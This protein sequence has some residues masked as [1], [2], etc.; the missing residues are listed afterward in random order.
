MHLSTVDRL[1]RTLGPIN[2]LVETL[3]ERLLPNAVAHA[4]SW[5]AFDCMFDWDAAWRLAILTLFIA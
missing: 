5:A 1:V 4:S 2:A 3:C